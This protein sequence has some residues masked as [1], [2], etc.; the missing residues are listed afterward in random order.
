MLSK[1]VSGARFAVALLLLCSCR[2]AMPWENAPDADEVNL[3]FTVRNNLLFLPSATVNGKTGRFFFASATP[4]TVVDPR[5]ARLLGGTTATYAL[6][7]GNRYS[8]AFTP[9]FIDLG[10]TGDAMIG[11]DVFANRG[12]TIDY[13]AGLLT[14]QEA[15]IHP[16]LMTLFHY[17]GDPA[18]DVD[19]DGRRVSAVVDTSSPDTLVLPAASSSRGRARVG[20]AGTEFRDVELRYANVERAHVGNRLLSKFLV[21]IDYKNRVVGLW[22][23]PRNP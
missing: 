15:G 4:R 18:I 16:D 14:Y 7:L 12:V 19:V 13:R 20:I 1:T 3:A 8:I 6:G 22:R 9:A 11:Y 2:P 23:D 17:E 5:V 10:A 21:A